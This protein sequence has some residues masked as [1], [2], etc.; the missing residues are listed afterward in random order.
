MHHFRSHEKH[1]LPNGLKKMWKTKAQNNGNYEETYWKVHQME[2]EKT[3]MS[4]VKIMLR[5]GKK[6]S[7]RCMH[8][9][10]GYEWKNKFKY[11]KQ[12]QQK[13]VTINVV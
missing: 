1:Q 10:N 2:N 6:T 13:F 9:R 12:Y 4:D 11:L 7:S 3:S 5:K 8:L